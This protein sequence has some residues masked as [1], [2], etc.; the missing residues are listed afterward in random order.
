MSKKEG[1]ISELS[2]K[3]IT[4]IGSIWFIVAVLFFTIVSHANLAIVF[5]SLTPLLLH[6]A[7]FFIFIEDEK[8]LFQTMW[9]LPVILSA[10]LYF[11]WYSNAFGMLKKVDGSAIFVLNIILSYITN[12]LFTLFYHKKIKHSR[13][14]QQLKENYEHLHKTYLQQNKK[15]QEEVDYLRTQVEDF[16]HQLKITKQNLTFNLRSIEDKCKSINFVIGR[17]YGKNKGGN[18]KIRDVLRINNDWYNTF[19]ELAQNFKQENSA[20]LFLALDNI[21]NKLKLFEL[22]ENEIFDLSILSKLKLDRQKD[23]GNKIIDILVKNDNDPVL[24]YYKE[25]LE[26]CTKLMDYMRNPPE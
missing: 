14:E 4:I 10:L 7:F 16:E 26:V 23:G 20:R 1:V 11:A 24:D 3:F 15:H 21:Y 9:L 18:E 22:K 19:S 2:K 5:L 25:A 12:G 6:I 13:K 17:V 8:K